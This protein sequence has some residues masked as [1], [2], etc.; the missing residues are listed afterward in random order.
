M[1]VTALSPPDIMK[2]LSYVLTGPFTTHEV[3]TAITRAE[4][5]LK[6]II[7]REGDSNGARREAWYFEELVKESP[8]ES[9]ASQYTIRTIG[10]HQNLILKI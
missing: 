10:L 5:K 9:R 6:S 2:K 3:E 4:E 8:R 1:T 7:A